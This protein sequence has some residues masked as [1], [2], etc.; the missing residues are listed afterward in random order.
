MICN[1]TANILRSFEAIRFEPPFYLHQWY[2]GKNNGRNYGKG[3]LLAQKNEDGE[4]VIGWA[5][6]KQKDYRAYNKEFAFL[7]A[8]DRI[9]KMDSAR[10]PDSMRKFVHEFAQRCQRY[11]RA[12]KY[13]ILGWDKPYK[14]THLPAR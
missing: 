11:F 10:F 13:V 14:A 6:C 4:I 9:E 8:A 3:L 12:E 2:V 1:S 7:V 5:L